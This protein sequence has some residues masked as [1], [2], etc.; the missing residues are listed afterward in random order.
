M[1]KVNKMSISEIAR[2][3]GITNEQLK[4]HLSENKVWVFNDDDMIDILQNDV[5]IAIEKL[6]IKREGNHANNSDLKQFRITGLFGNQDI[7]IDFKND[8]SILVSENGAGKTTVLKLLIA[9]LQNNYKY[10]RSVRFKTLSLKLRD[11]TISYDKSGF[12]NEKNIKEL[13]E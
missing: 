1:K 2:E 3:Y 11:K 10:L 5:K 7:E 6:K 12:E 13:R 4:N 8:I 9:L